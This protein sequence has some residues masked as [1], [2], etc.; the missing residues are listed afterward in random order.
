MRRSNLC[1]SCFVALDQVT[2]VLSQASA[3]FTWIIEIIVPLLFFVV[4]VSAT[5]SDTSMYTDG[6]NTV[7]GNYATFKLSASFCPLANWH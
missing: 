6:C 5:V 2:H 3:I 1:N 4:K 7:N